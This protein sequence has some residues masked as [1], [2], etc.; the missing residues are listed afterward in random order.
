MASS[1][2][3]VRLPLFHRRTGKKK[4]GGGG[5]KFVRLFPIVPDFSKKFSLQ[6]FQTCC[7]RGNDEIFWNVLLFII[8]SISFLHFRLLSYSTFPPIS[9]REFLLYI[10]ITRSYY[11]KESA[12]L[13][14]KPWGL[15]IPINFIYHT[16]CMNLFC[17]K[18]IEIT[19]CNNY[20]M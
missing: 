16:V 12:A 18:K 7:R 5:K 2:G 13:R 20:Y 9:V 19:T 15:I 14:P 4:L 6:T 3:I 8:T 10:F 11:R 17:L 1:S